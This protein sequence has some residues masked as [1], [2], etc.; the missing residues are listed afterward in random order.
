MYTCISQFTLLSLKIEFSNC[1]VGYRS[2]GC[3]RSQGDAEDAV[4]REEAQSSLGAPP[5]LGSGNHWAL[6][7]LG[8]DL[9][10][11]LQHELKLEPWLSLSIKQG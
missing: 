7:S 6:P 1:S 9:T 11:E 5:G 4:L 2:V 8:T 3:A 10:E